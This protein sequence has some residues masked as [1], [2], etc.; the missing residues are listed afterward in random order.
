MEISATSLPRITRKVPHS[1][2][3]HS[4]ARQAAAPVIYP[5]LTS[6]E[7]LVS[8]DRTLIYADIWNAAGFL[9]V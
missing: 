6:T 8:T 5:L 7:E 2:D 9:S 4:T 3:A 1:H